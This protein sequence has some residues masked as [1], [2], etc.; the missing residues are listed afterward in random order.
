M[1]RNCLEEQEEKVT[2]NSRDT[3]TKKEKEHF[4]RIR[5]PLSSLVTFCPLACTIFVPFV[6]FAV[7]TGIHGGQMASA[8]KTVGTNQAKPLQNKRSI[9]NCW[10]LFKACLVSKCQENLAT[11][12]CIVLVLEGGGGGEEGE[13]GRGDTT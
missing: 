8:D 7:P 3:H 2:R 12:P 13:G 6:L 11:L 9:P 10:Y 4:S 5:Q 1:E